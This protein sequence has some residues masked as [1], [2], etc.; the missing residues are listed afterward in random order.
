MKDDRMGWKQNERLEYTEI[1]VSRHVKRV[2]MKLFSGIVL[3]VAG[4]EVVYCCVSPANA[5]RWLI[6]SILP[7]NFLIH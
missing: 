7:K 5:T 3:C 2:E 4:Y 1:T 6:V